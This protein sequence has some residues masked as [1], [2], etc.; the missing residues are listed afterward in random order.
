ME[1]NNKMM[2]KMARLMMMMMSLMRTT[3]KM[4]LHEQLGKHEHGSDEDSG[5]GQQS[6]AEEIKK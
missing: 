1:F 6:V 4:H 5:V 3:S 2:I